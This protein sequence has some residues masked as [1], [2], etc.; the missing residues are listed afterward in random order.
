MDNFFQKIINMNFFENWPSFWPFLVLLEL[1]STNIW[2]KKLHLQIWPEEVEFGKLPP[3]LQK[4]EWG[5]TNLK[6]EEQK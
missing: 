2:G 6:H 4:H 1:I 3:H 5:S